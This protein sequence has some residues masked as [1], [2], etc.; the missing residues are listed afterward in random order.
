MWDLAHHLLAGSIVSTLEET[1]QAMR[2]VAERNRVIA[3]TGNDGLV[4]A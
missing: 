4:E 1:R 3:D 2:I